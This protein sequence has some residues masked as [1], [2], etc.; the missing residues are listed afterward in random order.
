MQQG[1][2]ADM[3]AAFGG[4]SNSLF[5]ASGATDFVTK[6]TT[7]LAIAFMV[8]S[9]LLVR[10]YTSFSTSS[11]VVVNNPLEGSVVKDTAVNQEAITNIEEPAAEAV[12]D[13]EVIETVKEAAAPVAVDATANAKPEVKEEDKK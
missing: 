3:G 10:A 12:S 13:A 9:I 7:S 5:G 11:G 1:K 2:G 6:L 4:S 8:T